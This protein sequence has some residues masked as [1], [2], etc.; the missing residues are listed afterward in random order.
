[1]WFGLGNLHGWSR[2]FIYGIEPNSDLGLASKVNMILHGDG[3][4]NIFVRSGLEQFALYSTTDRS[5]GLA[6]T[7]D[8][9]HGFPY[10][11]SCNEE[12]DFILTNPPFSISLSA[13]EKRVIN[14]GF[15]LGADADSENLFIERWYQLLRPGG[16]AVAVVP[17]TVL[18]SSSNVS[19]RLFILKFF[20]IRAVISL[21][22]VS[23]KPFTSTKTCVIFL[24]KKTDLAVV[25]WESQYHIYSDRFNR[26]QRGI[27]STR[28]DVRCISA[29]GLLGISFDECNADELINENKDL[30]RHWKTQPTCAKISL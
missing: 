15:D 1:M 12:F 8:K 3:S 6:V 22:Y 2:E 7:K 11:K 9:D 19:L 25:E 16:R 21:P 4:T 23:F 28:A 18:D 5:H 29:Q 14:E 27:S 26:F 10:T 24:E 20:W 13:D 30:R 17:E